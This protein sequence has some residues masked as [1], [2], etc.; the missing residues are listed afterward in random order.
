MGC[1]RCSKSVYA[2]EARAVGE[3]Q[4][5]KECFK[6]SM[7]NKMLDSTNINCHERVLFCKTCHGRKYGPKGYGFGS[8]AGTLNMDSGERFADKHEVKA[9]KPPKAAPGEGCPRC[10]GKVFA[11][12]LMM[13]KG[14]SYHKAC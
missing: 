9:Y 3:L 10:G 13:A 1:P 2:A 7:C 6:C 8:G 5:H 4:F 12:E 11:A 14:K